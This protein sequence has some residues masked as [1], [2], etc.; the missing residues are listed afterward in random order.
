MLTL[1]RSNAHNQLVGFSSSQ[2]QDIKPEQ[3]QG[4]DRTKTYGVKNGHNLNK[5]MHTSTA[6]ISASTS[7][8]SSQ[9]SPQM[10]SSP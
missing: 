7:R 2:R 9:G 6:I 5:W 3:Q 8:V 1:S 4:L 10:Y